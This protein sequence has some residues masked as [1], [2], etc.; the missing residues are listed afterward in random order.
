MILSLQNLGWNWA[1]VVT[2]LRNGICKKWL[3]NEDSALLCEGNDCKAGV[4]DIHHSDHMTTQHLS[5]RG[6]SKMVSH[7]KQRTDITKHQTCWHQYPDFLALSIVSFCKLYSLMIFPSVART[8]YIFTNNNVFYFWYYFR[9][10]KN[11]LTLY[12]FVS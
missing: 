1:H 7:Y 8:M 4:A 10:F 5:P 3:S 11:T 12:F 6:H 9:W 2:A